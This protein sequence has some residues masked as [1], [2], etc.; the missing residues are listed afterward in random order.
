MKDIHLRAISSRLATL[1]YR[2]KQALTKD[3]FPEER[4]H[5][6]EFS[7]SIPIGSVAD[8][9]VVYVVE[10][11]VSELV[12][13]GISTWPRKRITTLECASGCSFNGIFISR[14]LR[15][16]REVELAVHDFFSKSRIKGEWF[17]VNWERV[18]NKVSAIARPSGLWELHNRTA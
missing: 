8:G 9:G 10:H 3:Q 5:L 13:V 15:D 14:T 7:S 18:V 17:R 12:K 4:P 6:F 11:P 1:R 2:S 16:P